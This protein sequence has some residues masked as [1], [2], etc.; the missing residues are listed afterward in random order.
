MAAMSYASAASSWVPNVQ[1]K[2]INQQSKLKILPLIVHFNIEV[3]VKVMLTE[4]AEVE[5]FVASNPSNSCLPST[6]LMVPEIKFGILIYCEE[7]KITV[8]RGF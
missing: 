8:T 5:I 3:Q 7:I 1:Y 2:F 4:S 6:M